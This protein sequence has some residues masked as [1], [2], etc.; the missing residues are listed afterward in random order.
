MNDTA[1]ISTTV[2]EIAVKSVKDV[3]DGRSKHIVFSM[4]MFP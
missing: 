4:L 2:V 1:Q 3:G